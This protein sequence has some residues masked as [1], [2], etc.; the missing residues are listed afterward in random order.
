MI[1]CTCGNHSAVCV[2]CM[3]DEIDRLTEENERLKDF[4]IWMTGCG[5][6]FCQHPYFIKERDELL[7]SAPKCKEVQDGND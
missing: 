2:Y 7:K 4:A 3:E 6:D 5:Y 1:E